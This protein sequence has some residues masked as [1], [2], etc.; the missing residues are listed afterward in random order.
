MWDAGN[1]S[2]LAKG[3]GVPARDWSER[4]RPILVTPWHAGQDLGALPREE[5]RVVFPRM[6]PALWD[7]L[8]VARHGD[9][10]PS[11]LRLLSD[12][13]RFAV[14]DP[15]IQLSSSDL[16][17]GGCNVDELDLFI[18]N[19]GSYPVLHPCMTSVMLSKP[20]VGLEPHGLAGLLSMG[21]PPL[22]P[23][24]EMP[25]DCFRKRPGPPPADLLAVGVIYF[26]IL[27]GTHPFY[28]KGFDAPAW[29]GVQTG[30]MGMLRPHPQ[31]I[32]NDPDFRRWPER[33]RDVLA[34]TPGLKAAER[35]LAMEL[36]SLSFTTREQLV[37]ALSPVVAA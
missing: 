28:R 8:L 35:S 31:S 7:A 25:D 24:V 16:T 13:Q 1:W 33:C 22:R 30:P 10:S 9:L 34:S 27:T 36:L 21:S 2:H 17:F 5:Q 23:R 12:R 26:V 32:R 29:C 15:G 6:L 19:T 14:L 37:A 18:T 20:P 3:K 11:N 4:L